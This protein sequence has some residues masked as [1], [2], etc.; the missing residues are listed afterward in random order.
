MTTHTQLAMCDSMAIVAQHGWLTI[1][2]E[3]CDVPQYFIGFFLVAKVPDRTDSTEIKE[4]Q[5][6]R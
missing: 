5:L 2:C 6:S 1:L 3:S 4:K